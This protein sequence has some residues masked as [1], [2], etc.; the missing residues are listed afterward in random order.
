MRGAEHAHSAAAGLAGFLALGE[1]VP[2]LGLVKEAY[3]P[4]T[5]RIA[6]ALGDE[7]ADA[8]FWTALG[9]TLDRL[10]AGPGRSRPARGSSR[11]S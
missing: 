11:A 2:R 3:F 7:L 10:G 5:S 4:P 8:A 1:A 9:D 6:G